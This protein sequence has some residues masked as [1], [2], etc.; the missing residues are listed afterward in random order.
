MRSA[1]EHLHGS[2]FCFSE[3][4]PHN[5]KI[6]LPDDVFTGNTGAKRGC[7][8]GNTTQLTIPKYA[9]LWRGSKR[10]QS[11]SFPKIVSPCPI[12]NSEKK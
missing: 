4:D 3:H 8:G 1:L 5:G 7:L 11:T 9:L 12:G 2:M 10:V 6:N